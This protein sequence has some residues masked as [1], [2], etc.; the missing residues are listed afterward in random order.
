MTEKH[1]MISHGHIENTL[2][3][4]HR[5]RGMEI[6]LVE[7]GHL[8]WAVDRV[9]EVLNPGTVFFTLPWQTHGSLML[10]EP[11]N[12]IFYALFALPGG[13]DSTKEAL[14]LPASL[15]FSA[16]EQKTLGKV[17]CGAHRHAWSATPLL[18]EI[19]PEL[20]RRL[21]GASEL[22][23]IATTSLLRALLIELADIISRAQSEPQ[24][25]SPTVQKVKAFLNQ[26]AESLDHLI[27]NRSGNTYKLAGHSNVVGRG[28]SG[29]PGGMLGRKVVCL[30]R[31]VV[32]DN[33][34]CNHGA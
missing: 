11:P 5:N 33:A 13:N 28:G 7:K 26:V 14:R 19:F 4:P 9:P 18:K 27:L 34:G 3:Y 12:R 21:D 22:D 8:E 30:L 24:W 20:V 31:A 17:F 15:K 29:Q 25:L 32:S 2:M 6:V 16:E 23:V 10:R 1:E